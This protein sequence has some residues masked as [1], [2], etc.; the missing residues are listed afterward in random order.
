MSPPCIRTGGLKNKQTG[1]AKSVHS[2]GVSTKVR[3]P[4][5]R[6]LLY[7]FLEC[8]LISPLSPVIFDNPLFSKLEKGTFF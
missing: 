4:Q 1:R 2:S 7:F 5:G 8:L 3:C 6:V